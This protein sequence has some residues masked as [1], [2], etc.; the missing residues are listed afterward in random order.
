M[1]EI[2]VFKVVR[3]ESK[4]LVSAIYKPCD[5]EDLITYM[6]G[7]P[8]RPRPG[9]GPLSAFESLREALVF[10]ERNIYAIYPSE[11]WLARA[12]S[13]SEKALWQPTRPFY[14]KRHPKLPSWCPP[15][16]VLCDEIT[17]IARVM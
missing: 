16:T 2:Y 9:W 3:V 7:E 11:I 8:T 6:V 5:N 13:S 1:R 14:T 12:K 17:L 10:R 4:R 15:G